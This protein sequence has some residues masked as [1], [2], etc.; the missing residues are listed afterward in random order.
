MSVGS[1]EEL[2]SHWGH[3]I[4][5]AYYGERDNPASVTI[6]CMDCNEVLLEPFL[7]IESDEQEE[8]D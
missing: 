1:K 3:E 2:L 5:L 8:G 6:E 7:E 4:E